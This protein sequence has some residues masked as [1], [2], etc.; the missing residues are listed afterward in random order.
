MISVKGGEGRPL[1][2]KKNQ[3]HKK[4]NLFVGWREGDYSKKKK[5][6]SA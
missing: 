6:E 5:R 2:Q 3:Q 4:L 1:I